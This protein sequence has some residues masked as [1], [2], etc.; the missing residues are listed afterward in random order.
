MLTVAFQYWHGDEERTLDLC[1]FL[2]AHTDCPEG[3]KFLL[4]R[5]FDC[6]MSDRAQ[7]TANAMREWGG[8][9]TLAQGKTKMVGYPAGSAALWMDTI[10]AW[11]AG[12]PKPTDWLATFEW[13]SSPLRRSWFS[14]IE[15]VCG[16][17]SA[18]K[19]GVVG[20][21]CPQSK[22]V[23]KHVN[24]N[25]AMSGAFVKDKWSTLMRLDGQPWDIQIRHL[26]LHGV[27]THSPI[28][29]YFRTTDYTPETIGKMATQYAWLH[30]CID[31]SAMKAFAEFQAAPKKVDESLLR[32]KG[33]CV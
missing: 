9:V 20:Y 23:P 22:G 8:A 17:A 21:V 25:L 27:Y 11:Y 12:K 5:R 18:A 28:A 31:G 14:D 24:G 16:A 30:G 1:D 32:W 10:R 6:P 3:A 4:S 15:R 29:S 2:V 19:R 33:L 13:D 7:D 26:L